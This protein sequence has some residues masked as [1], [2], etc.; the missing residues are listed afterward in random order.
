MGSNHYR[1]DIDGL[2]AVAVLAVVL[3]HFGVR[4]FAGGYVG[5]DVFFVISGYLITKTISEDVDAGIFSF[6]KFYMARIRRIVPALITVVLA[7]FVIGALSMAP[8]AFQELSDSALAA[9][10]S[11]SN[12]YFW[13]SSGYFDTASISKPLLHTWSLGVEEQF[14][15]IWPVLLVAAVRLSRQWR[16]ACVAVFALCS[17][18]ASQMWLSVDPSGAYYLL[19]FRAFELAAG[20]FLIFFPPSRVVRFESVRGF[21]LVSGVGCILAPSLLFTLETPFPGLA[22]CLPVFGA[23]LAISFGQ[24]SFGSPMLTNPVSV[25]IGKISYSIYLTHWPLL[26]FAKYVLMRDLSGV[27]VLAC[28]VATVVIS[29]LLYTFVEQPFRRKSLGTFA[30]PSRQVLLLASLGVVAVSVP[31]SSASFNGGWKWRL[32][33]YQRLAF[34]GIDNPKKFHKVFY[35]GIACTIPRCEARARKGHRVYVIGD[36]HARAL[37]AGFIK[38]FP[39]IDFVFYGPDACPFYSRK[40]TSR[41]VFSAACN[42]AKTKAFREIQQHPAPIIL[43]QHWAPRVASP[44]YSVQDANAKPLKFKGANDFASFLSGQLADLHALIGSRPMIVIGGVPRYGSEYSP[45]DCVSR[46]FQRKGCATSKRE[47]PRIA[48]QETINGAIDS[49]LGDHVRFIDP[50]DFLCDRKSCRNLDDNKRPIYS[51]DSHLSRWGSLYLA[52]KMKGELSSALLGDRPN[53]VLSASSP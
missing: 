34:R 38:A 15:F 10:A 17:L 36:S 4:P 16:A 27:E 30:M 8:A 23:M 26:V 18:I 7:S 29:K 32:H 28:L 41:D 43:T 20:G 47:N 40:F 22:A 25:W 13:F 37:Y 33:K 6:R 3:F 21:G 48:L 35:G 45:S 14:Y 53:A 19:P 31:A 2:R 52:N 12:L 11:V 42:R 51:D 46:P 24:D 44:H 39:G 5:V 49:S 50:Y 9:I 1:A